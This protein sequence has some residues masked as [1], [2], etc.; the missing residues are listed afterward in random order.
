MKNLLR[1]FPNRRVLWGCVSILGLLCCLSGY[2]LP[3]ARNSAAQT[4][5]VTLRVDV[6]LITVEASVLDKKGAPVR[7]LKRDDFQLLEDG[8]PQDIVT[9]AE[10]NED[11][12]QELPNSLADIDERGP[13]RGKIVLIFFD[14]SHLTPGQLQIAHDTA[15]KYVKAHMRPLDLFA[16]ASYGMSLKL[17]QNYTHDAAKVVEAIR[18]PAVSF[19]PASRAAPASAAAASDN[20]MVIPAKGKSAISQESLETRLRTSALFRA[21]TSLSS[22]VAQVKGRKVVLFFSEDFSAGIE[23]QSDFAN[24]VNSAKRSNVA[25]YTIDARGMISSQM[26][27]QVPDGSGGGRPGGSARGGVARFASFFAGLPAATLGGSTPVSGFLAT[28]MFQ[29]SGSS[30][31]SGQTNPAKPPGSTNPGST[32]PGTGTTVPGTGSGGNTTVPTNPPTNT[33]GTYNP[34]NSSTNDSG[35]NQPDFSQFASQRMDNMLRSLAAET[36]GLAIFNTS[37]FT[38]R[39]NDVD[40][41]LSNYYILGFQSNNPKRDGKFRK[42][43]VKTASKGVEIRHRPGYVDPRPVDVLAG[44]KGE[45]ALIDAMAAPA[46]AARVPVSFRAHYFYESP[47]LAR[48]SVTARIRTTNIELSRRGDQLAGDLN[49][50]GIAYSDSGSVAARFSETMHIALQKKEDEQSFRKERLAY[51]NHFKLRPGKYQVKVAVSDEKGR[52]GS[53]EQALEVPPMPQH[54]L[55]ASSLVVAD[56]ISRM[57]GL[58]QDLQAKLLDEGDMILYR[59]FQML[60]STENQLPVNSPFNAV[61]KMYNLTGDAQPRQLVAQ[62]QLKGEDGQTYDLGTIPIDEN[63]FITSKTEALVG[64]KLPIRNVAAGKYKL[65]VAASE[66]VSKRTVTLETDLTFR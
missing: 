10:V 54:D 53:A 8:K 19:A 48:V 16:V 47:G 39:L 41:E 4:G 59:G 57:P 50:M 37:E 24:T 35:S 13:N 55:A 49:V 6:E 66:G 5:N 22:T 42:I 1:E 46:A 60:P 61:F 38:A 52:V 15:E 9:F 26:I 45:R 29:Q 32:A 40:Q 7:G 2:L 63:L 58:I 56:N 11:S 43:E 34:N 23:V 25:Y 62:V 30:Q 64:I 14:D 51:L 21:L 44:S 20:P 3:G 27:S 28:G 12:A 33:Y 36:G 65:I 31:S 18:L 17:L